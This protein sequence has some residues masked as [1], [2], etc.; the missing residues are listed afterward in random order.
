M[1]E[2]VQS[3]LVSGERAVPLPSDAAWREVVAAAPA[4]WP[5]P[6][7][8]GREGRAFPLAEI[9]PAAGIF[10]IPSA[11]VLAPDGWVLTAAGGVIAACSWYGTAGLQDWKP[12]EVAAPVKPLDGLCLVLASDWATGNYGH[13]LFD[14]LPR[15]YL[16]EE[17][18][19][20]LEQ[21]D[22]VLAP[23]QMKPQAALL[24]QAGLRE[25]QMLWSSQAAAYTCERLIAP[26]FPGVRRSL[27]AWAASFLRR[28][29]APVERSQERRLYIKRDTTRRLH[30]EAELIAAL[31]PLGFAAY[32]PGA[33]A[34][35]PRAMF[36]AAE[37]I[38]GGHGAGLADLVFAPSGAQVVELIPTDQV[39]P[40]YFCAAVSAGLRYTAILCPSDGERGKGA[41]GPSP[42][43]VTAPLDVIMPFLAALTAES[44]E[45]PNRMDDQ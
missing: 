18:G 14:V 1:S 35:D 9:T 34:R 40:Y 16:V 36:A 37:V 26:T 13:F 45:R 25:D 42:H 11:T 21:F 8:V 43:D 28:R 10:E 12:T 4:R 27:T 33:D 7:F 38:V 23:H 15:L 24:R 41:W 6:R 44:P 29:F 17:A 31:E 3:F 20:R 39:L 30:N 2:P 32:L 19:Y 5:E 22:H